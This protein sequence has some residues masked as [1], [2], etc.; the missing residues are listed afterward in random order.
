[1][2]IYTVTIPGLCLTF[3]LLLFFSKSVFAAPG[4]DLI[5]GKLAPCPDSPNCISTE[6]NDLAPIDIGTHDPAQAW[7]L[8]QD[9]IIQQGGKIEI[10]RGDYLWASFQTST[11]QFTDD[12][13]ARLD[14]DNQL[15]HFRSAS[16]KGYYDFNANRKRLESI[17]NIFFIKL[18]PEKL[19][20]VHE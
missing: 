13:E 16:R 10:V 17:K 7:Q 3:I 2:R 8:L 19:K 5:N 12:V 18:N 14:K 15:I 1:M 11:L 20:N 6:S 4:K 9:S